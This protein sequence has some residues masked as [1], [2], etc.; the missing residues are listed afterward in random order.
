MARPPNLLRNYG[1]TTYRPLIRKI[2]GNIANWRA[3]V[4]YEQRAEWVRSAELVA[5]G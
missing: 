4:G 3:T 5:A 1:R 2:R